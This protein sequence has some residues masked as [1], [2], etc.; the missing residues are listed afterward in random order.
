VLTTGHRGAA[1]SPVAR[2]LGYPRRAV[3]LTVSTSSLPEAPERGQRHSPPVPHDNVPADRR[4]AS[5]AGLRDWLALGLAVVIGFTSI[6]SAVVAWRASVSAI[7]AARLSSL[8]VQQ[9]ARRQQLE[10]QIEGLV[11]QDRRFVGAY[12]EHAL[13]ARELARQADELRPTDPDAAD[14]LDL[15]A[16]G[17]RALARSLEPFFSAGGISLTDEGTVDYDERFVTD[18]LRDTDP[19]L[20]A[21]DPERTLAQADRADQRTIALIGVAALFVAALLLL[22]IGQVVRRR[23][24]ART[25]FAAGGS[26]L[27][28]VATLAFVVVEL[29]WQ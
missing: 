22:T 20:R 6:M 25:T 17:E 9:G 5:S 2:A 14:A 18:Y 28:A 26:L 24:R 3:S 15:Q 11:A 29:L 27:A 4:S 16:H 7:D 8:V 13:A 12:L 21:L 23:R 10:R 1:N 19:E